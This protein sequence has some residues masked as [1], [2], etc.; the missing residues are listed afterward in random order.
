MNDLDLQSPFNPS[1]VVI[2]SPSLP[3]SY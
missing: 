2:K 3:R 1:G